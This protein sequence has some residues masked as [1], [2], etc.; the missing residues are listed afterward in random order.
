MSAVRR[1]PQLNLEELLY[2]RWILGGVLAL[3]SVW[4]LFYLEASLWPLGIVATISILVVL[5]N[6]RIPK[7]VPKFAWRIGVPLIGAFFAIDLTLNEMI[8]AFIRLNTLLVLYRAVSYRSHREDLQL[9]VLCLFLIVVTGVL[10]VSLAFAVQI[11]LFAAVGMVFLFVLNIAADTSSDEMPAPEEWSVI[12]RRRFAKRLWQVF[13]LRV[14][15]LTAGLFVAVIGI[16]VVIFLA[17]PRFEMENSVGLLRFNSQKSVTG[18]SESIALGEVTD[19]T[20]D[21]SI[22]MR[23]DLQGID[24]V[25]G[26]PY[27]RMVVLDEYGNGMFRVSRAVLG[28]VGVRSYP[29]IDIAPDRPL[30]GGQ[31]PENDDSYVIFLEGGISR[32]LPL[33][34]GFG[35]VRFKEF[36]DLVPN[37]VFRTYST[38]KQSATLLSLKIEGVDFGGLIH[39]PEFEKLNLRSPAADVGV[40]E[41]VARNFPYQSLGYPATT[42][43][44]PVSP[45]GRELLR[46]IVDEISRGEELGPGEFANRACGYLEKHHRYS[47]NIALPELA[48]EA[49]PVIRWLMSGSDGHC[50]FFAA[51]FTLLSRTAGF[52]TRAVTGFKGGTWNAYEG[53]FMVRNSDAH[54]WCEVYGGDGSW[55]RVDPTPGAGGAAVSNAPIAVASIVTDHSMAAYIDSLRMIWYRRIVSF[56]QRSQSVVTDSIRGLGDRSLTWVSA[57]G[58]TLWSELN[59]WLRSP[60][61]LESKGDLLYIAIFALTIGVLM[62]RFGIGTTDVFQWMRRGERPVRDRAGDLILDLQRRMTRRRKS[63]RWSE[64]AVIQI[65]DDLTVIRYGRPESWPDPWRVFRAARRMR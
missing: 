51:A 23:V 65:I 13:D 50:E 8:P 57:L 58:A 20:Q 17:I 55:F 45:R 9:A 27:W 14:I 46:S 34:S 15:G 37:S 11:L 59:K 35:A 1:Q 36:H 26:I 18:F 62:R 29:Y 16:S 33:P 56:D 47:T 43:A 53:Y 5:F 4:T 22:A 64:E 54:A 7:K 25:P 60:W 28:H 41:R 2:V 24:R 6:P 49:D 12:S 61:T 39:D 38:E 40:P 19:I 52:S 30:N 63:R 31:G 21:D 3:L 10:T 42:K 32:Y 48:D 44:V